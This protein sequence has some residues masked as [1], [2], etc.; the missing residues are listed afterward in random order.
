M[1]EK[2][3]DEI[4]KMVNAMYVDDMKT[5]LFCRCCCKNAADVTETLGHILIA[6]GAIVSFAAGVWDLS[7]LSY[8]SGGISVASMSLLKFSSYSMKESKE[9]TM[10]VNKL[11]TSLGLK[12]I[13]DITFD[14]TA[15]DIVNVG[16]IGEISN[17]N[18]TNNT[19]NIA[20]NTENKI[21]ADATI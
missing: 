17:I 5:T 3:N 9:R 20:V 4:I 8:I 13:P 6:A 1:E 18:N 21:S 2:V 16:E 14:S 11:L 19:N 15:M 7:Y 12:E 10:Q